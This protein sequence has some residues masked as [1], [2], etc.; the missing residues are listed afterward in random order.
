[1]IE[2]EGESYFE[3]QAEGNA[4][5]FIMPFALELCEGMGLDIGCGR[6]DWAL[7]GAFPIDIEFDDQW[8]AMN[9]PSRQLVLQNR[10][11]EE[12]LGT[13]D[14]T[15]AWDYIFSSHCLEH[16]PDW[17]GAIEYWTENLADGG[18]LFLYLPHYD[19]RYWRPWNNR[20]HVNILTPEIVHDAMEHYNYADIMV[21][22]RDLNHSFAATG[23]KRCEAP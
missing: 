18:R 21:S 3:F 11:K 19:Q 20:K 16:L 1:M 5:Q 12:L 4:A 17:V 14:S 23:I 13:V 10:L 8:D 15:R 7:D 9:L 6:E 2:F 22:G